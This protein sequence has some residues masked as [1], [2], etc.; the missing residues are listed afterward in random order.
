MLFVGY[1]V[2]SFLA[3]ELVNR[4]KRGFLFLRVVL[5]Y[6]IIMGD[7]SKQRTYR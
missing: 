7:L 5:V 6:R 4:A 1:C 3:K 2:E